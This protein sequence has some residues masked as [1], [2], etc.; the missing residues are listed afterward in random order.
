LWWAHSLAIF[1]SSST[2]FSCAPRYECTSSDKQ[3]STVLCSVADPKL[4]IQDPDPTGQFITDPGP[5]PT[6]QVVSDPDPDPF[7]IFFGKL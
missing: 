1:T 3:L 6:F 5:D 2:V 4:L 7:R